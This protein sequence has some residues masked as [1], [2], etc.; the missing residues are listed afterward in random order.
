MLE[1]TK[2]ADGRTLVEGTDSRGNE[3][4][5]ILQSSAWDA[6]LRARK[7]IAATEEFDA[8][9]EAFFAPLTEVADRLTENPVDDYSIVEIGE[10]VEGSLS[11]VIELDTDGI[12]LRVLEE[13]DGS[14]L[15]WVHGTELVV[16]AS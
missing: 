1:I 11:R 16:V 4:S 3:G 7:Q 14:G 10:T 8:A 13:T 12:L 6:V 15:R 2:L 9:V 5:T